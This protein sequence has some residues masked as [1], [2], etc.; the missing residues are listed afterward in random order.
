MP[1]LIPFPAVEPTSFAFVMPR[2]P[3]TSAVSESGV[4]DHRLWGTVAVDGA[5]ELEF[6]N[7][8]TE[9]ATSIL[10]TFHDSYSGL[11]P[12]E[13]PDILF[14]GETTTDRAFINSVTTEAGL[15]W[16]WPLGQGAPNPRKS[17]TYKNRCT[18]P[19]RLEARLENTPQPLPPAPIAWVSRLL[20]ATRAPLTNGG[21]HGSIVANTNG[22]SFQAFWFEAEGGSAV[23]VVVVKRNKGGDV[24]WTKWTSGEFGGTATSRDAIC[25][26]VLPLLDGG[27]IVLACADTSVSTFP[28]T[29]TLRAWRIDSD[30]GQEWSRQYVGRFAGAV[31]A[32]LSGNFAIIYTSSTFLGSGSV[33]RVRPAL[34][35]IDIASGNYV[36]GSAYQFD[37]TISDVTYSRND[38]LLIDSGTVVL[39][40]AQNI[41]MRLNTFG[42][43]LTQVAALTNLGGRIT[44][45]P[46]GGFVCR[47][48]S[49]DLVVLDST[50]IVT[51]IHRQTNPVKTGGSFYGGSSHLAISAAPDGTIYNMGESGNFGTGGGLSLGLEITA[52][53]SA[54]TPS[55]YGAISLGSGIIGA[56]N[57]WHNSIGRGG[58][59]FIDTTN[60]R[61]L[62]HITGDFSNGASCRVHA[63]AFDLALPTSPSADNGAPART[64][65]T[66]GCGNTISL[67]GWEN[68]SFTTGTPANVTR[69]VPTVAISS[70][71]A[72]EAVGDLNMVEAPLYWQKAQL[73]S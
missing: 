22:D 67:R 24:L 54:A 35:V 14:A 31:R 33:T 23:R 61:G 8:R 34:L 41:L 42:T 53:S 2:H 15:Q 50:F 10:Q 45:L 18:L 68:I 26:Q 56:G 51:A 70:V 55:A 27:C 47:N 9:V 21:S 17:L 11:L 16:F 1:D 25:P 60:K 36:V 62:V 49:N 59:N 37:G 72:T 5:L 43:S 30:G 66:Q 32:V 38:E 46:S 52:S 40:T 73:T 57:P 19:V 71:T 6:R 28:S 44:A 3:V 39:K 29:F 20:T 48:G 69:S 64:L 63:L 58:V 13:L 4:Q 12:L 7:I 65:N